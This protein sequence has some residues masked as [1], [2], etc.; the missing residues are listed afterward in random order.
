MQDTDVLLEAA[1]TIHPAL[2]RD[3]GSTAGSGVKRFGRYGMSAFY[4]HNYISCIHAD[5]DIGKE[6]VEKGRAHNACQGDLYPCVQLRKDKC[7]RQ[8]YNFAYVRWG[9]VI[10]T[11]ANAVWCLL[12]SFFSEIHH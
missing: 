2:K 6:D 7:G 8:D 12:L 3:L 9:I 1:A 10:C 4:C 11:W 5:L